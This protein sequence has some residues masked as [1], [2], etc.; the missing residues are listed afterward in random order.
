MEAFAAHRADPSPWG[1][2]RRRL[3]RLA[4]R[5]PA[6]RAPNRP[7]VSFSFDDPPATAAD[8]GARVLEARGLKGTYF[9]SAGLLGREGPMGVFAD[10]EAVRTLAQAGHEI[11]CHTFSHLDC[12]G[13]D[14]ETVAADLDRNRTALTEWSLPAAATFAYPYGDVG[15]P[16]KAVTRD[17]FVLSRGLHHGLVE[18]GTDL[19]QAPAVGIEGPSGEALARRWL[20]HARA[21]NAWLILY[22]HDVRET[23]SGWGCTPNALGRLADEALEAGFEVV[24]VA[25]G[26]RRLA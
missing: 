9:V 14:A 1:K 6:T 20:A 8:A 16:A 2:A 11:A 25:Q 17:R 10:A 24:T 26:A 18:I 3:T 13:A 4:H 22:T 21:R 15:F 7:T 19:N 5:K 12:G 23:P